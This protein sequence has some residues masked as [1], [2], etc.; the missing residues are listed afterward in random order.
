MRRPYGCGAKPRSFANNSV[1]LLRWSTTIMQR[2]GTYRACLRVAIESWLTS[3]VV[4]RP[5]LAH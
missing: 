2:T 3:G 4:S 1:N 5:R